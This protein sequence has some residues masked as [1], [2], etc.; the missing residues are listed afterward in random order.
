[1]Q[2]PGS[3]WGECMKNT[4]EGTQ[5]VVNLDTTVGATVQGI[6]ASRPV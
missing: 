6:I 2:L 5:L 4:R 1:M 3:E